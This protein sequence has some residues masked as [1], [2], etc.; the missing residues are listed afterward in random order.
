MPVSITVSF[1]LIT[2][3]S[4]TLIGSSLRPPGA[5]LNVSSALAAALLSTTKAITFPATLKLPRLPPLTAGFSGYSITVL[6]RLPIS[7]TSHP[8]TSA[9]SASKRYSPNE[10]IVSTGMY[11]TETLIVT[12]SDLEGSAGDAAVMTT[13]PRL[14]LKLTFPAR[15]TDAISVS[16]DDQVTLVDISPFC[17]TVAASSMVYPSLYVTSSVSTAL[18]S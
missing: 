13:E 2:A 5:S 16:L 9:S 8:L 11:G 15:V 18:P 7:A 14:P 12:E 1:R 17:S 3:T 6:V 4:S 10:S